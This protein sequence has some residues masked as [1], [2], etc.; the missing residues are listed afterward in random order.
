LN[1]LAIVDR[2]GVRLLDV[3]GSQRAEIALMG[4]PRL[5]NRQPVWSSD[6]ARLAWSA[7][8][9]RQA[10]SP[11]TLAIAD[12]DGTN[13]VDHATV[14]PAFYL[15]WRPDGTSVAALSDGPLGLELTITDVASGTASIECRNAPLYFAWSPS[16]ALAIHAGSGAEAHL[17]VRGDGF[18][19]EALRALTLGSFTAPAFVGTDRILV[20]ADV[21]QGPQL[22]LLNG[23]GVAEMVLGGAEFGARFCVDTSGTWVA[24]ASVRGAGGAL[25]VH[26]LPSDTLALVDD[27]EP[28]LFSWSPDGARLL[29]ARVIERGD[30]PILEWCTWRDG[31]TTVHGRGR[32]TATFGRE[33]LPFHEQFTRSHAW[34]SADGAAFAYAAIDDFANDAIWVQD[35]ATTKAERVGSGSM[36]VWSPR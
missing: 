17:D 1:R 33:V 34:W 31:E 28:A 8:D 21:G 12:A 16:S 27:R 26:H 10:D 22:V 36:A 29:F 23:A 15:A 18:D 20:V 9:R 7:F 5:A 3:V 14:F 2:K 25:L 13:R 4:D 35:V 32:V 11:A 6:S 19:G 30:F 24:S